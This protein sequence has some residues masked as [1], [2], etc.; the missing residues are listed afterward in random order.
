LW[1]MDGAFLGHAR[2]SRPVT[3]DPR[4]DPGFLAPQAVDLRELTSGSNLR[5]RRRAVHGAQSP[6]WTLLLGRCGPP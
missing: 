1:G 2:A 6:R 5:Q 3:A 4:C